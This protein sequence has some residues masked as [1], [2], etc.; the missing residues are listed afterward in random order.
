V[1]LDTN[2]VVSGLLS[3]AGPPARIVDL[4]AGGE[5]ALLFDDRLL[6]E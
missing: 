1:V 6:N 2:V 4:V 5:L 3:A